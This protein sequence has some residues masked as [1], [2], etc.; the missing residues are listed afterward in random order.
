VGAP[1]AAP[2]PAASVSA[3]RTVLTALAAQLPHARGD[4]DARVGH[5]TKG[6]N[7]CGYLKGHLVDSYRGV[8]SATQLVAGN[9]Q[10]AKALMTSTVAQQH[11]TRTGRA[12][13]QAALDSAFG[14]P[15]VVEHLQAQWP[16]TR[17]FV[18]ARQP[19]HAGAALH[20]VFGAGR[21]N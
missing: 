14:Y 13:D 9:A 1:E 5:T 12:P 2:L 6:T 3:L 16:G 20:Q 7:F 8:I 10:Q 21:L 18:G 15:P 17:V 4:P 11:R 19:A